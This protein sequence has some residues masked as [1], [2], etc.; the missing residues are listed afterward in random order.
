MV[1]QLGP[2]LLDATKSRKTSPK[3]WPQDRALSLRYELGTGGNATLATRMHAQLPAKAAVP[4]QARRRLSTCS[5][6]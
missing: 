2:S 6:N 4:T 5:A 3:R 1:A